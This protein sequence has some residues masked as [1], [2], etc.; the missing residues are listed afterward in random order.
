VSGTA[1]IPG[2]QAG[3]DVKAAQNAPPQRE[4]PVA[5][6]RPGRPRSEQADKAIIE[7]TLEL[8]ADV[9]VAGLSIEQVA[10]AAGVGKATIY[11]RWKSKEDLVVDAL[12]SMSELLPELPGTSVRDDLVLLV[13]HIRQRHQGP[14]GQMLLCVTHEGDRFPEMRRRYFDLV[15]APRRAAVRAVLERGRASGELRSDID[16]DVA[17]LLVTGPMLTAA[18]LRAE[19]K[20][21]AEEL[22]ARLVDAALDGLRAAP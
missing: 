19:T 5:A 11:R 17:E 3:E 1:G 14:A 16:L 8:L 15:V 21:L 6:K 13:D 9:G 4:D 2:V 12:A 22:A 10:A 7:A 20:P 18:K